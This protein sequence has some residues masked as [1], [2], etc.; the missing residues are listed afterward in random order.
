ML[1]FS[2]VLQEVYG[3][4]ISFVGQVELANVPLDLSSYKPILYHPADCI[5]GYMT[6]LG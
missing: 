4:N 1:R 5:F 6:L 3:R 2:V